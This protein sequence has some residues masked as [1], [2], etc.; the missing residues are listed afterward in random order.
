LQGIPNRVPTKQTTTRIYVWARVQQGL[1]VR[2]I[3]VA[4][5]VLRLVGIKH[6]FTHPQ[7][8]LYAMLD[9]KHEVFQLITKP[10]PVTYTVCAFATGVSRH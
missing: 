2:R 3:D 6:I 10:G 9:L 7:A 5:E 4:Q 8:S 1:W